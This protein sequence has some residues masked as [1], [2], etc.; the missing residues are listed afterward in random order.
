MTMIRLTRRL[1]LTGL[2]LAGWLTGTTDP[3]SALITGLTA[4]LRRRLAQLRSAS[5]RGLTTVEVALITAV[6][7]GLATALLVAITAV[8]NK[9]KNKIK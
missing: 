8:V 4:A 9:N 5:D 7:L 2:L 3:E 6:L 1:R